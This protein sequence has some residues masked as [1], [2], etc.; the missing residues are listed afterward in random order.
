MPSFR[1]IVEK[2]DIAV[3]N[4][5]TSG[6]YLNPVQANRF[7]RMVQEQTTFMQEIRTV[8]MNA[9]T[10]EINKIGFASRILKAAPSSGNALSS[11]NRSA[12][13]TEKVTLETVKC[14]A[15][16]HIPYDVLEDNIERGNLEDTIMYQIAERA[17]L[18]LEELII[19]GDSTSSDEYLA[20][21]DG[22]IKLATSHVVDYSATPVSDIS[23]TIFKAGIKAMPNKYL[24]NRSSMRFYVS[25]DVETEYADALA[26]RLTPLGDTRIENAYR[27]LLSPFGVPLRVAALMPDSKYIFTNPKNIIW[28]VQRDMMIET[29]RDIRTQVIIIVL[30]LRIALEFEEEDAVVKCIGLNPNDETTTTT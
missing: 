21:T 19:L 7:I 9:P 27:N 30:S 26:D 18:D 8:P 12:P 16:V 23:K 14:V 29:D 15:E 5:T 28:G 2:A 25:P 24:R 4:L 20:Q 22:I 1:N 11:S 17:A 10:M 3:S 6:G 13:T